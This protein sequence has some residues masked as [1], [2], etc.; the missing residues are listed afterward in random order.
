MGAVTVP[1]DIDTTGSHDV[2]VELASFINATSDGTR[3]DFPTGARY[4]CDRTVNVVDKHGLTIYGHGATIWTDDAVTRYTGRQ[5][6]LFT[7]GGDL[8]LS[9]L[10][11][12]GPHRAAGMRGV[13]DVTHEHEHAF[14]TVG[15]H[16]M[17]VVDCEFSYVHGDLI[18]LKGR[19]V[20][21]SGTAD[22]KDWSSD[23]WISGCRLHHSGRQG[24]TF[25][26]VRDSVLCDSKIFEIRRS[27]F[28]FE[29]L[30]VAYNGASGIHIEANEIGAGR[31]A[32]LSNHGSGPVSDVWLERNRLTRALAVTVEDRD[33]GR[34]SGFHIVDN[35]SAPTP[36]AVQDIG[37]TGGAVMSFVR[38]DGVEVR[39][40][41][42]P[43]Q[44]G[45]GMVLVDAVDC[46]GVDVTGNDAYEMDRTG[47]RGATIV[48]LRP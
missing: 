45:R 16:S 22:G 36:A 19:K 27:T 4:R 40:N 28:E 13:F 3:I 5:H 42:Q 41:T 2:T 7:G 20:G 24:V 14:Q 26:G 23:I 34:R 9:R 30:A 18:Y 8:V 35:V 48:E 29:P 33:G 43:V 15:V 39:G 6:L 1:A 38:V 17:C 10:N 21:P 44:P 46:T 37:S 32:V 12:R 11:V 31:F 47:K 25:Q